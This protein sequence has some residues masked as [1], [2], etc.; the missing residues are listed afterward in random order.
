MSRPHSIRRVY[1]VI[2]LLALNRTPAE[3]AQQLGLTMQEVL[4]VQAQYASLVPDVQRFGEQIYNALWRLGRVR[5]INIVLEMLDSP[6]DKLRLRAA[7]LMLRLPAGQN[8]EDHA[9]LKAIQKLTSQSR[10]QKRVKI[11]LP[12]EFVEDGDEVPQPDEPEVNG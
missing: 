12:A 2:A 9:L 4:H 10:Q 3:I 1:D 5:A 11:E 6:D 8:V 7:D